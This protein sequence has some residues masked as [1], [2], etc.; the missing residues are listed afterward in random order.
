MR[1]KWLVYGLAVISLFCGFTKGPQREAAP[2]DNRPDS[3]R[4]LALYTEGVK[5]LVIYGDSVNARRLSL[6]ALSI[7]SLYAPANHLLSRVADNQTLATK[8][9]VRAYEQDRENHHYLAS[10]AEALVRSRRYK[11]ALEL[12]KQLVEKSSEPDHFRV[13]ALLYE[14]D[15]RHFSAISVID[16]AEVRFGRIPHFSRMRQ[17]LYI[18]TKQY[19]KAEREALQ[20]VEEAPYMAENLIMLAE[21]YASTARDSLA[22]ATYSRAIK[23]DSTAV[24]PWLALGDYLFRQRNYNAYLG[25]VARLF[26]SDGVSVRDK[27]EQF[28]ALTSNTQ[29]YRNYFSQ[30]NALAGKLAIK[31]P[32]NR[33]VAELYARHLTAS[34]QIDA[35]AEIYKQLLDQ[36]KPKREELMRIVE[37]ENYLGRTDSVAVYLDRALTHYPSDGELRAMR[38]HLHVMASRHAE[39]ID[40]YKE[41]LKVTKNDTLRSRLWGYIGDAEH[42]LGKTKRAY[43]A[44]DKSLK[45]HPENQSVL[46]NYAYF[47]AVEGRELNRALEMARKACSIS[48]NNS[49]FLDTLAWVLYRLGEYNEAKKYM[50][51]AI[52]LDRGSSAELALHYGDILDALGEEFMAQTYWRKALERGY[53]ATEIDKRVEAQRQRKEAAKGSANR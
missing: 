20:L 15:Q 36:T 25:I 9:A 33:E 22:R 8:A 50:Q 2:A 3:L 10:A 45:Y 34:G 23:A 53:N 35:A 18:A 51:Q 41:A 5:R 11:E 4:K 46:N 29:F 39:A 49:T 47:L 48:Q 12:Y 31:Y 38:G 43:A 37:I 16:S 1:I 42:N 26:D 30:I 44:F 14:S 21:V 24:M 19:D 13:L 40:S 27:I 28:K 32:E 6:N 7:D 17:Q 52:S